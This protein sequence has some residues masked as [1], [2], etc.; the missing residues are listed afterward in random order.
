MLCALSIYFAI[1]GGV[2]WARGCTEGSPCGSGE[3]HPTAL[4]RS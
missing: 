3:S 4:G 1:A 2:D